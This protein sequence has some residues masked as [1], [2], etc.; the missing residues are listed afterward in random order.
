MAHWR[1]GGSIEPAE[2]V[3]PGSLCISPYK[4]GLPG[5]LCNSVKSQGV[6][7]GKTKR[8]KYFFHFLMQISAIYIYCLEA[9][10]YPD[11]RETN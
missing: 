9:L 11:G 8:T 2:A 7:R 5:S 4:K 6:L 1:F 3:V 10:S